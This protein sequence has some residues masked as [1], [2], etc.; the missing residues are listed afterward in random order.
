MPMSTLTPQGWSSAEA[1]LSLL[2]ENK[3]KLTVQCAYACYTQESVM[4]R[5]Q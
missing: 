3:D 1:V 2:D 5:K 4:R